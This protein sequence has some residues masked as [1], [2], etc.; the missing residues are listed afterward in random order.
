M[1]NWEK[2]A[3]FAKRLKFTWKPENFDSEE[4]YAAEMQ[5]RREFEEYVHRYSTGFASNILLVEKHG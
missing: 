4:E 1:K 5:K 3:L 2:E